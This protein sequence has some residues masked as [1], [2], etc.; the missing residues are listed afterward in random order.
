MSIDSM[1]LRL[2]G[3][4]VAN[5]TLT[6]EKISGHTFI[7]YLQSWRYGEITKTQ[8][9][10]A[11]DFTHADDSTDLDNLKTWFLDADAGGLGPAFLQV[12]ESRI[13]FAR[14]KSVPGSSAPDLDGK[15]GFAVKATFVA[16]ADGTHSLKNTGPVAARFNSWA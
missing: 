4:N 2:V 6:D 3:G 14:R 15:F 1:F 16:G 7:D 13:R 9:V 8:L 11:E 12:L 5:P 10:A